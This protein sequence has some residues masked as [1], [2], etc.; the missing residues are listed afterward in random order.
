MK[1][2]NITTNFIRTNQIDSF[3]KLR[4]L[5][6]F[7]QYPD[8]VGTTQEIAQKLHLA[9][10]RRVEKN[11]LDLNKVEII[12][13]TDCCWKLCHK[14]EVTVAL[15][16]LARLFER[17]LTRQKLLDQIRGDGPAAASDEITHP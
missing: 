10:T 6:F 14:P 13:K 9:E 15:E 5:L 2:D 11:I 16:L 7:Q 3:Q 8:F 12:T 17:P 1:L 4:L